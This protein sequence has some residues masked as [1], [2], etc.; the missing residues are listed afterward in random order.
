[1]KQT[2]ISSTMNFDIMKHLK[3]FFHIVYVII[4]ENNQHL[5]AYT[6]KTN[7]FLVHNY[8]NRNTEIKGRRT[9]KDKRDE[10][11]DEDLRPGNPISYEMVPSGLYNP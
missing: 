9:F 6:V 1:M 5:K 3:I 7:N 4:H 11:E 10:T 2:K 8:Q